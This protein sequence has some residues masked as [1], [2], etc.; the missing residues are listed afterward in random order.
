MRP[1]S[2]ELQERNSEVVMTH[3]T[4]SKPATR[5]HH[6]VIEKPPDRGVKPFAFADVS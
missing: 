2:S 1:S 4:P 6:T 3:A 5:G